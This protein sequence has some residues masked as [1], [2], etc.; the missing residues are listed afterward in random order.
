MGAEDAPQGGQQTNTAAGQ[1][2]HMCMWVYVGVC[3]CCIMPCTS[4]SA[5]VNLH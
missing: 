2:S 1:G 5:L 4:V 3:T